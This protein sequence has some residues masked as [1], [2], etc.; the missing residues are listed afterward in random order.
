MEEFEASA[1]VLLSDTMDQYRTFQ[2]CERWLHCPTKLGNQLLFQIPPNRQ[3]VLIERYVKMCVCVYCRIVEL[4]SLNRSLF[5]LDIMLFMTCLYGKSWERSSQKEPRK[6]WM[7]S[8]PRL[9]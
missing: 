5:C 6:T 1:D 4:Q 8:V 9:E 7:I 3:A 2:M